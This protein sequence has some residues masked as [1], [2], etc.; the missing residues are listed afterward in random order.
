M[1]LSRA[2]F[3]FLLMAVIARLCAA[4]APP[5]TSQNGSSAVAKA[6][7]LAQAGQC[8]QALPTLKRSLR[9]VT[10]RE[11]KRK[12]GLAGVRCSMTV[13]RADSAL[14]FLQVLTREFP[15]DA[16]VLYAATHAYSDLATRASQELAQNAPESYQAHELLAESFETQGKWE[17][18]EKEYRAILEHDPKLPGIHFRLGRL[19]LSKPNPGPAVADEA[20]REMEQELQLDPS[21]AGAEYVLGEL[22]RQNQ[23]WS[24]AISRFSQA[25]KLD[26]QF[27]EAFLGLG[28]SLISQKRYPDAIPPL[29]TAVRLQPRNPDAHY[30]LATAYTRAGRKQDGEKEFAI[31]RQLTEDS[32]AAP[33]SSPQ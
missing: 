2:A 33:P 28:V 9:S 29:E 20:K 23:Q 15:R 22:A 10:D 17:D 27:G 14:D 12:A 24:E 21:N 5:K 6:V 31:H 26:P 4:Q 13:N 1:S 11:L 19:L 16:D 30:N 25:A 18:A 32:P 7:A 3:S 8:E